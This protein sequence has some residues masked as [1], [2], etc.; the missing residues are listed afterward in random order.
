M[1]YKDHERTIVAYDLGRHLHYALPTAELGLLVVEDCLR[2]FRA[3]PEWWLENLRKI[4]NASVVTRFVDRYT[5]D[6]EGHGGDLD[7][8]SRAEVW[9]KWARS[10]APEGHLARTLALDH[11]PSI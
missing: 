6:V 11:D 5:L 10:L 8:E 1:D 9:F 4:E 2:A 7:D 3:K